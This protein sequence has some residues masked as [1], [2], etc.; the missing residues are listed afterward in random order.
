MAL[1]NKN[2]LFLGTDSSHIDSDNHALVK[3]KQKQSTSHSE[4]TSEG[5][6]A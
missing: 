1:V 4:N 3:T 6:I 5:I 2:I